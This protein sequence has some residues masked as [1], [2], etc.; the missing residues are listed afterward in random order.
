VKGNKGPVANAGNDV[1]IKL[2]SNSVTLY[3]NSSYDNDGPII[4]YQ[5][6]KLSGPYATIYNPYVVNTTVQNMQEGT[7]VFRLTVTD[8]KGSVSYADVKVTVTSTSTTS[9]PKPANSGGLTAR[10]GSDY[11]VPAKQYGFL[12]GSNSTIPN[13]WQTNYSWTRVAGPWE[14]RII[15]PHFI[16]SYLSD[17][18][19]GVYTFRLTLT[20]GSG[21]TST[22]DVNVTVTQARSG[23]A[24]SDQALNAVELPLNNSLNIQT[25]KI[26]PNPVREVINLK[27]NSIYKGN[28]IL[29][30]VDVT[31]RTVK[32]SNFRKEAAEYNH[33]LE[34]NNLKPGIYIL[35]IKTS[36]GEALNE[37]FIK[38]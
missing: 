37:K 19:P 30:V 15:T 24:A 12:D 18:V 3:G 26:F 5:W 11:S 20:D 33:S 25:L 32:T 9:A 27:W 17:L 21:N 2:P 16:G 28:A 35:Q 1:I 10:A 34:V 31:G 13:Y 8:N 6:A 38:R 4:S 23:T 7:Y 29:N 14:H 36:Q 22:D